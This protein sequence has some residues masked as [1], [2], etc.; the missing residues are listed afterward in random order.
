M[1]GFAPLA[2]APLGAAGE[3]GVSF[4]VALSDAASISTLTF[5]LSEFVGEVSHSADLADETVLAPSVFNATFSEQIEIAGA[6]STDATFSCFVEGSAQGNNQ[7]AAVAA[8]SA[9]LSELSTGQ[10]SVFVT[11]SVFNAAVSEQGQALDQVLALAVFFANI[12]EDAVGADE[13]L[14]RLLWELI[15]TSESTTWTPVKTQT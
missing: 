9:L 7:V 6:S 2:A 5:A 12:S 14:G 4:D 15:N 3:G 11:P 10:D 13:M 8:F 1:L